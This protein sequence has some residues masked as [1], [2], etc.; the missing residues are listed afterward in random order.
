MNFV[1]EFDR[2]LDCMVECADAKVF[3]S[4][5]WSPEEEMEARKKLVVERKKLCV[6]L[7]KR[8]VTKSVAE[9][10]IANDIPLRTMARLLV[11]QCFSCPDFLEYEKQLGA[12]GRRFLGMLSDL[13][14]PFYDVDD[15]YLVIDGTIGWNRVEAALTAIL[16]VF[17]SSEGVERALLCLKHHCA[18]QEALLDIIVLLS[19]Q[20][21]KL[22]SVG[23]RDRE[24]STDDSD[25]TKRNKGN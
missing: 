16:T 6:Q 15:W 21:A 24:S 10:V 23:K 3:G 19:T 1:A 25:E 20:S 5:V 2:R 17:E 18:E 14:L 7:Q 8:T 13:T 9:F 11:N 12:E 4:V 22:K